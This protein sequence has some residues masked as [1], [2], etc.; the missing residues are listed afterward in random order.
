MGSN[1]S[2][3]VIPPAWAQQACC[4][5][6]QAPRLSVRQTLGAPDQMA[7]AQCGCA[8][9]LEAGGS[10]VALT[11]GQ[12]AVAAAIGGATRIWLSVSELR[13][14]LQQGAEHALEPMSAA[15]CAPE[16]PAAA[17]TL[18]APT[19]DAPSPATPSAPTDLPVALV[20]CSEA[21]LMK[22]A[23]TLLALGNSPLQIQV[24]LVQ[25]GVAPALVQTVVEAMRQL[26]HQKRQQEL[27]WTWLLTGLVTA[28]LL[29]AVVSG[30]A[31]WRRTAGG[32]PSATSPPTNGPPTPTG[33]AGF[34][35]S[36]PTAMVQ[37][38]PP[39]TPTPAPSGNTQAGRCPGSS[40]EASNLFGG[41]AADW[42]YKA[43]AGGWIMTTITPQSIYVP[44]GM[45]AGYPQ[46]GGSGAYMHQVY[47]PVRIQNVNF[48]AIMCP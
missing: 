21:E 40:S 8:F 18:P 44:A 47:G 10:R 3:S 38:E 23:E 39:G 25:S 12:P 14:L 33:A 5:V 20:Q 42:T 1:T 13:G 9:E 7:C 22:R 43:D 45:L 6:C 34:F 37:T 41:Q 31:L 30:W 32:A 11:Q 15:G 48:I 17:P 4:P 24:A 16:T 36:L 19:P 29:I 27:R 28:C 35:L 46:F 2:R 26:A